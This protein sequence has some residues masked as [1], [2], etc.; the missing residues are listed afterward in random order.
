MHSFVIKAE[1]R[2]GW[3][4]WQVTKCFLCRT[5]RVHSSHPLTSTGLTEGYTVQLIWTC[6]CTTLDDEEIIVYTEAVVI[7]GARSAFV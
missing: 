7:S 6:N 4:C 2:R 3:E 5:S 1:H